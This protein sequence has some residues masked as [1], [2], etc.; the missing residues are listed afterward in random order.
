MTKIWDQYKFYDKKF[1]N[2]IIANWKTFFRAK[3]RINRVKVP[4]TEWRIKFETIHL[5][6]SQCPEYISNKRI[7][8]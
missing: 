2:G 5:T 6:R 4:P 8:Q 3:E 7:T 1:T